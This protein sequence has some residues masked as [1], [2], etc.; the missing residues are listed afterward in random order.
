MALIVSFRI[1]QASF[2]ERGRKIPSEAE[3]ASS[4]GG[5]HELG[6]P[7]KWILI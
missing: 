6:R 5:T 4:I 1:L 3:I 7:S 2:R